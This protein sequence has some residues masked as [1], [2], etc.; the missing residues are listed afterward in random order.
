M[1][2][3]LIFAE[4]RRH[5]TIAAADAAWRRHDAADCL[6]PLMPPALTP[7]ITPPPPDALRMRDYAAICRFAA[8]CRY[9]IFIAATILCCAYAFACRCRLALL[10]AEALAALLFAIFRHF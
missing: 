9:F 6:S 3:R 8:F 1:I 4:L 2:F 10:R 5:F 7:F